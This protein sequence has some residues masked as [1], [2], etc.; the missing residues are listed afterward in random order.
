MLEDSHGSL[1]VDASVSLL[2]GLVPAKTICARLFPMQ[3][4]R[5]EDQDFGRHA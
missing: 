3:L 1:A 5:Y 4:A 2:A